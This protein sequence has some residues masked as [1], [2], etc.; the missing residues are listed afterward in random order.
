MEADAHAAVEAAG[1]APGGAPLEAAR[2]RAAALDRPRGG[3][4][5][6]RRRGGGGSGAAV[7]AAALGPEER[8]GGGQL[9]AGGRRRRLRVRPSGEAEVAEAEQ[10]EEAGGAAAHASG[11]GE[12]PRGILRRRRARALRPGGGRPCARPAWEWERGR[13]GMVGPAEGAERRGEERA[14]RAQRWHRD[15][16]NPGDL[17][18]RSTC[19]E[20]KGGSLRQPGRGGGGRLEGPRAGRERGAKGGEAAVTR[21]GPQRRKSPWG[22]GRESCTQRRFYAPAA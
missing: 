11:R 5:R 20:W 17:T 1:P 21:G 18:A 10:A 9:R 15:I 3:E 2:V 14:P 7:G 16:Y 6:G 8:G 4:L 19:L 12:A 13:G 22:G